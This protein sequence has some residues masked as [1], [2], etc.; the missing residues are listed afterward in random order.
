MYYG[1][2]KGFAENLP[3]SA[4]IEI[5]Y[6]ESMKNSQKKVE[7]F[8]KKYRLQH[9]PEIAVLDLVSEIGEVAKE[10]LEASDYGKK[11]PKNPKQLKS[12]LGDSLYSLIN[13]ANYYNIDLEQALEMVLEKYQK[14]LKKGG[15]S[16]KY[17]D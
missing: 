8:V 16:S 9:R 14:R 3:K 6:S 11:P 7:K 4:L 17:E 5:S 1:E 2:N 15:A 10:I 13:L 12:E